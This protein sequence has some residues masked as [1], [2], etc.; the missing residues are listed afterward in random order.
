MVRAIPTIKYLSSRVPF[1]GLQMIQK[2]K[3]MSEEAP[4]NQRP[5]DMVPFYINSEGPH[6]KRE[7]LAAYGFDMTSMGPEEALRL[8]RIKMMPQ[9][10][11]Y[12]FINYGDN[13]R[14]SE[15]FQREEFDELRHNIFEP[16]A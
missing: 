13:G 5:E 10:K 14:V 4:E 9:L 2:I 8:T 12:K 1:C 7:S 6:I 3:E 16:Y 15:R 11:T